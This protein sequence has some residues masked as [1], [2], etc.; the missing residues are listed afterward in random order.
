M[1]TIHSLFQNASL[2]PNTYNL[3][4]FSLQLIDFFIKSSSKYV[5]RQDVCTIVAFTKLS[6]PLIQSK[7]IIFHAHLQLFIKWEGQIVRGLNNWEAI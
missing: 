7:K 6:D 2:P 1:S 5:F 3:L 4:Y